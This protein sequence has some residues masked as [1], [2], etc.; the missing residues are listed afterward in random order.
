MG[1]ENDMK[2]YICKAKLVTQP[3]SLLHLLLGL[4]LA[5]GVLVG[6]ILVQVALVPLLLP[7][8]EV[9]PYANKYIFKQRSSHDGSRYYVKQNLN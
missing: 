7:Q 9:I 2:P 6:R 5:E 1:T 8:P 4:E 3:G